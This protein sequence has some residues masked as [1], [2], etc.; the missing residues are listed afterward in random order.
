MGICTAGVVQRRGHRHCPL[1]L[2]LGSL[3]KGTD[4]AIPGLSILGGGGPA[5]H[6]TGLQVQHVTLLPE[7][8]PGTQAAF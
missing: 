7:P 8:W 6:T 3:G 5:S 4:G 1:L 2:R